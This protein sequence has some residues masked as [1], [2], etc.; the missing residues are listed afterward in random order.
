MNQVRKG[1]RVALCACPGML[2]GGT[3]FAQGGKIQVQWLGQSAN[4]IT[5]PGGK[6]IG[7]DPGDK[8]GF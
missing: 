6:V 4:K 1:T 8:V 5:T 7:I 3:V 2:L